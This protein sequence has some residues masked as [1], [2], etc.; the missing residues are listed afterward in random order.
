MTE[1][2]HI[3]VLKGGQ[4]YEKVRVDHDFDSIAGVRQHRHGPG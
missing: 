2:I 1:R 3:H 4:C